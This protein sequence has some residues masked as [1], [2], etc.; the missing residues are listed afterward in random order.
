MK[1]EDFKNITDAEINTAKRLAAAGACHGTCAVLKCPFAYPYNNKVS[2]SAIN[3][4]DLTKKES[5]I[6][7]KLRNCPHAT[8]TLGF[9]SED[10]F[11]KACNEFIQLFSVTKLDLTE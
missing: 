6:Y 1:R 3:F 10:K 9:I 8:K 4:D 7:M 11:R 2:F 5:S